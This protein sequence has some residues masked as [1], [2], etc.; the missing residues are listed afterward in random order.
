MPTE[1][2]QQETEAKVPPA[3]AQKKMHQQQ[4]V[5]PLDLKTVNDIFFEGIR[6]NVAEAMKVHDAQWNWTA[7]SSAEVYKRV[8]TFAAALRAMGVA[9]GDRVAILAENRWEWAVADFAV[10]GIG[11]ID[12]PLYPTLLPDQIAAMLQNSGARLAV[13]SG[14]EA[15]DKVQA[16]RK[17]TAVERVIVM[18]DVDAEGVDKMSALM[19]STAPMRRGR[20][21]RQARMP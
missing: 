1:A 10:L 3:A 8:R 13:V 7:I 18:D 2:A 4:A 15:L 12:V 17:D 19:A 16:V 6:R 5:I 20:I 14:R 9:P 21:L 11:A